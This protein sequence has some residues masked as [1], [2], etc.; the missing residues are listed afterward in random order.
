MDRSPRPSRRFCSP[1]G[2]FVAQRLVGDDSL[3]SPG[4]GGVEARRENL[5]DLFLR[6]HLRLET[7]DAPAFFH[8]L[9]DLVHC[10]YSP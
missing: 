10:S 1:L 9:D 8:C 2:E 5:L 7:A 4:V 3:L 6:E